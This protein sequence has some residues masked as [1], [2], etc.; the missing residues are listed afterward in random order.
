MSNIST[1]YNEFMTRTAAL[2][3]ANDGWRRIPN[4]IK[5]DENNELILQQGYGFR[6]VDAPNTNRTVGCKVS[7]DQNIVLVIT[8]KVFRTE[9]NPTAIN[10]TELLLAED[11]YSMLNYFEQ[12]PNLNSTAANFRFIGASPTDFVF[13]DKDNFLSMELNFA[14]EY[15]ELYT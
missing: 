11:R 8:R 3:T 9:E 4:P 10:A 2:L 13:G 15:F 6:L 14:V 1:I 12:T 7:L 5:L